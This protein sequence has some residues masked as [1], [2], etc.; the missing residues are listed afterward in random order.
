MADK[1]IAHLYAAL[2]Q[3]ERDGSQDCVT[4]ISSNSEIE[5]SGTLLIVLFG[6]AME[7]GTGRIG[8]CPDGIR[9]DSYRTI[10]FSFSWCGVPVALSFELHTEFLTL[11]AVID[12]SRKPDCDDLR[13]S[14]AEHPFLGELRENLGKFCHL[15]K[16]DAERCEALHRFV[17]YDVWDKLGSTVLFPMADHNQSLGAK[18]VDFRGIVLGAQ[19]GPDGKPRISVPF[20]REPA[21]AGTGGERDPLCHIDDFDKL[22][23]FVRCTH[24]EDTEFTV[25]RFLGKRA[26][27]ATALGNQQRAMLEGIGR[28]LCYLL[29][30][31]TLNEWQ[32]GRLIYRVHRAGAARIAAIMHFEALRRANHLLT[33]TEGRLEEANSALPG[34]TSDDEEDTPADDFRASLRRHFA[35]VEQ[36]FREISKLQLDGT[37]ESRI[38]R[39]RYYVRQFAAATTALRIRRVSGFQRYDE[40]VNQRL[41]PVFEYIDSLGRKYSRVQNERSNLLGRIRSYDSQYNEEIVSRAQRIADLALSCILVPYYG[42]YVISHALSPEVLPER[43]VWFAGFSFGI[44]MFIMLRYLGGWWRR[45][46]RREPPEFLQSLGHRYALAALLAAVSTS[47][48]SLAAPRI[49][50]QGGAAAGHETSQPPSER[51]LQ[52]RDNEASA[53]PAA[54]ETGGH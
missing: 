30:E 29:Y 34:Q 9:P 31:D 50:D 48:L 44:I 36:Q 24:K 32:L 1:A 53:P 13:G 22:W 14:P 11:T 2:L 47:L 17:Y 3:K 28:P 49:F 41:G 20:S 27:Y 15:E 5:A 46:L 10:K 26:F 54:P 37:L 51:V 43:Y 25:S 8:P 40:F 33:I 21:Q 19:A 52:I 18:F 23:S 42:S 45:L 4:T 35:F 38:E 12:A 16:L 6:Q 7:K 39:S